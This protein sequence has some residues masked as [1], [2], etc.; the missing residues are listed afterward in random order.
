MDSFSSSVH[1]T[2]SAV[3]IIFVILLCVSGFFSSSET[4]MMS[5]NRYRLRHLAKSNHRTAKRVSGLLE[6]LDRLLGVILIGNTLS[7]SLATIAG[8]VLLVRYW[9]D[10]GLA[11]APIVVT[12]LLL[13]FAEITPKTLAAL[14]PQKIAFFASIPLKLLLKL[15]YP[16]VVLANGI[17][18]GLLAIFRVPVKRSSLDRL[19]R[20]ELRT[21]VLEST[22]RISA[23]HQEMLLRILD[24]DQVTVDDVMVPRNEI[25]GIDL[26]DKWDDT[27][28]RIT[29]SQHTMLPVYQDDIDNLKGVVHL[30]D[31]INLLANQ[32]L[33]KMNLE[34]IIQ[35]AYFIL[36]GTSVNTQLLNFRQEKQRWGLVVDEYGDILGLVTLEDMLEEVVGEF[37]SDVPTISKV[38]QP[39][40]DGSYLVEGMVNIRE[41]N[42]TMGWNFSTEGPKTLSGAIIEYLE[43]IPENRVC[44]RLDGYVIEIISI[45]DNKIEMARVYLPA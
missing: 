10:I 32:A 30:R 25:Y 7:N 15:L 6:R 27:L 38:V 18:N 20:E 45:K 21:V 24:S 41:L 29:S 28:A 9:G 16:V 17:S 44:L 26:D 40:P 39:Q 19:S 33:N 35:E 37:T 13:I 42:R 3:I 8:T 23:L 31:A 14:Y 12:L 36:E 4:G 43:S 34:Q 1:V 2:N 5:L 11:L 22:G